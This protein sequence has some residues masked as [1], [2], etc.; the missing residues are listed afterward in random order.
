MDNN[1]FARDAFER[2]R[3]TT[4]D[5]TDTLGRKMADQIMDSWVND[6]TFKDGVLPS[7]AQSPVFLYADIFDAMAKRLTERCMTEAIWYEMDQ[8]KAHEEN[9]NSSDK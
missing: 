4:K 3:A 7:L 6:P 8:A 9:D 1:D 2:I 5:T